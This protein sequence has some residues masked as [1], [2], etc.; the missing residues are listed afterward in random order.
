MKKHNQIIRDYTVESLQGLLAT[1]VPHICQKEGE[2]GM[3]LFWASSQNNRN[4]RLLNKAADAFPSSAVM[5]VG[6]LSIRTNDDNGNLMRHG[7][8]P[9][10][11]YERIKTERAS[12]WSICLIET[13]TAEQ[14]EAGVQQL[15]DQKVCAIQFSE[16][17]FT[18]KKAQACLDLIKDLKFTPRGLDIPGVE[19]DLENRYH[20]DRLAVIYAP[21]GGPTNPTVQWTNQNNNPQGT[22]RPNSVVAGQNQLLD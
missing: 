12:W 19:P 9:K 22:R 1:S 11:G 2:E 6:S 8:D 21:S 7:C 5:Q 17:N 3:D 4:V 18:N 13:F 20:L 16:A 10:A 15:R 14:C